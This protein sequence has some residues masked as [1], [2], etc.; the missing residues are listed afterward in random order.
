MAR[1]RIGVTG[2]DRGGVAA[3]I[4]TWWAIRWAGGKA[5]HI[6]PG[7][8]RSLQELDGLVVGG[9]ADVDPGLYGQDPLSLIREIDATETGWRQRILGFV[10]YPLLWLL[11]RV[12]YTKL[13]GGDADR[14]RLEQALIREALDRG[15]PILGICRGMQLLNVVC[16]GTLH[17]NLEGFYREHPQVRSVLPRKVVTL[18]EGSR[19]AALTGTNP[20]PVNALH[21]QA[22][23]ELGQDLVVAAR[24]ASG[25]VQAIESRNA[26]LILGV[27]WHPEY[28]PQKA[29]HR[30]LFQGLV[31]SSRD[32]SVRARSQ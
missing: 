21:N 13:H 2:P 5:V 24:E 18:T 8:P 29:R 26:P 15:L 6:T 4:M 10:L 19:I 3:W 28:L 11:R 20:L 30:R 27:Q 22:V 17:Q 1:P 12:L 31:D 23:A 16:G 7:R 14:D 9:G 32:L 25:V